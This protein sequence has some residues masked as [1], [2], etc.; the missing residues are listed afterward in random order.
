MTKAEIIVNSLV[1]NNYKYWVYGIRTENRLL[2]EGDKLGVSHEWDFENGDYFEDQ[3]MD[4]IC[5]TGFSCLC[6]DGED[7]DIAAVD[8]TLSIQSH[9]LGKHQYLIAG[10][11]GCNWSYGND[12]GEVVIGNAIV[13]KVLS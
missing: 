7:D 9:Y 4:G 2:S 5:A 13:L 12:Q 1:A 10:P 3:Y 11:A 6:Y 8:R